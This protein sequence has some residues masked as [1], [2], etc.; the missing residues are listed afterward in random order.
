MR[1]YRN[2]PVRE[3]V[4]AQISSLRNILGILIIK[5]HV[6]GAGKRQALI[7]SYIMITGFRQKDIEEIFCT[8]IVQ[9][10]AFWS[11]VKRRMGISSIACNFMVAEDD[12]KPQG[13]AN[14]KITSD[15][16][17]VMRQ[18]D[19]NHSIA[20]VPYGPELE[21]ADEFRGVFLEELSECL[22]SHLPAD[23]FL[24]RYD[25]AWESFWAGDEETCTP[26]GL[27]PGPPAYPL[28][29]LRFNFS[30]RNMNFRKAQSNILP[31]N[32]VFLDLLRDEASLLKSMKSKTRYNIGL[33]LRKG[34][35]VSVAG[36]EQL[37]RWYAL[38]REAACRNNFF[39][40]DIEH[41]RAV[42]SS[43]AENTQ[44]PAEVCLLIAEHDK[45][46][47]AAM[48]LVITGNRGTYLYGASS[49]HKRNLMA[50]YALQ[51]KAITLA[52]EKGCSE[53]DMFGISPGPDPDHPM[54][55]LYRFKTGF[56]GEIYHS[57]GCWD[58][59]IDNRVYSYF[60]ASELTRQ[61]YHLS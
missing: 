43:R 1:H 59:P 42:L 5:S 18:I 2:L 60:A 19:P 29:E 32:T 21:P 27:W 51:W 28:Q 58:Y 3:A 10:T 35:T 12:I 14:R 53:Y 17:V 55:G 24:I 49:S 41:F 47:L 25:L 40:H 57:M 8:P 37:E 45:D 48:F 13:E 61:G 36:P 23:C 7:Q 16:L 56:G 11:E 50:T 20:Y 54:Y 26:E 33:A 6:Y 38:Y 15:L 30:T 22:R 4:S 44:S 9:Q 52:K 39:L 46:P 34:V 31:S